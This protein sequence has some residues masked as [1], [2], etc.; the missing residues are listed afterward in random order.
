MYLRRRS[1][2]LVNLLTIFFLYSSLYAQFGNPFLLE[3]GKRNFTA[4][5]SKSPKETAIAV[6]NRTISQSPFAYKLAMEK[7]G[8]KLDAGRTLDLGRTFGLGKEAV[9]IAISEITTQ[10]DTSIKLTISH[11]DQ[12]IIWLDGK[13]VYQYLKTDNKNTLVQADLDLDL[14]RG[15]HRLILKS[16]TKGQNWIISLQ[17]TDWAPNI[18]FGISKIPGVDRSVSDYSNWLICG[19]FALET[20][21]MMA[22]YGPE[23]EFKI[24]SVWEGMSGPV[25]WTIPK[26]N[27]LVNLTTSNPL[28]G[29][30]YTYSVQSASLA[31]TMSALG[32]VTDK[33][34]FTNYSARYYKN[35]ADAIPLVDYQ[36]NSLHQVQSVHQETDG[37]QTPNPILVSVISARSETERKKELVRLLDDRLKYLKQ[38]STPSNKDIPESGKNTI[39]ADEMFLSIPFLVEACKASKDEKEKVDLLNRVAEHLLSIY[40]LS[41]NASQNLYMDAANPG[42]KSTFP[43]VSR[44]NGMAI[45]A[46]SLLLQQLPKSHSKYKELLKI[47]T[48]HATQLATSQ[49]NK[50]GH[51]HLILTDTSSLVETSGTGFITASLA[52]GINEGWLPRAKF[53]KSINL[54]WNAIA[55]QIS[56]EGDVFGVGLSIQP[57]E[58]A[59]Q[60]KKLRTVRNAPWGITAVLQAAMEIEKLKAK[61]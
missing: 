21:G 54:G 30:Y 51:W 31:W 1:L 18:G 28:W 25:A 36:Q 29:T 27:P 59:R 57:S 2:F 58:D 35:M 14:K 16:C 10:V 17:P 37:S 34:D 52:K 7:T 20:S 13:E 32:T 11:N 50:T 24:G 56:P 19:P 26:T 47:F 43:F 12:L 40:R 4:W 38:I 53:E 49:N 55:S 46:T 22:T 39:R 60:Y 45:F 33:L 41:Y 6:A 44:S 9:A 23:K 42:R 48:V 3:G 5:Q 61:K 15:N 8:E